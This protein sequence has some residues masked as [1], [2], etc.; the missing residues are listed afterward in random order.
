MRVKYTPRKFVP[1]P[2][3]F[4]RGRVPNPFQWQQT[5]LRVRAP[6]DSQY[7]QWLKDSLQGAETDMRTGI[8]RVASESVNV[9][10]M[11]TVV[12]APT[13]GAPALQEITEEPEQ[14]SQEVNV[15]NQMDT[16]VRD[17]FLEPLLQSGPS[18]TVGTQLVE[19]QVHQREGRPVTPTIRSP[20][21]EDSWP[22]TPQNTPV[23]PV[24]GGTPTQTPRR[25]SGVATGRSPVVLR[26]LNLDEGGILVDQSGLLESHM[27]GRSLAYFMED[28]EELRSR[29][30]SASTVILPV[31]EGPPQAAE[32]EPETSAKESTGGSP[33][34]PKTRK[35]RSSSERT[36][37]TVSAE[38]VVGD[39]VFETK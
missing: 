27:M 11:Q 23:R 8:D 17:W 35:C 6:G 10:G 13:Q 7:Q 18:Q 1:L 15:F 30:S 33:R 38:T 37:M 39:P 5:R 24:V 20:T 36:K 9:M 16:P 29:H 22:N 3:K 34:I 4:R 2:N 21:S 25:F 26:G 12:R 19:V 32:E 31:T 14:P 28:P